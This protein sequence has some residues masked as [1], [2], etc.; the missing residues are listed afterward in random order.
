[1]SVVNEF[2]ESKYYIILGYIR[3]L[4]N[5]KWIWRVSTQNFSRNPRCVCYAPVSFQWQCSVNSLSFTTLL[6][7]QDECKLGMDD[8][9]VNAE[10]TDTFGTYTCKCKDGWTGDGFNCTSE[11]MIRLETKMG[12]SSFVAHFCRFN[13]KI[14]TSL[15]PWWHWEYFCNLGY[16]YALFYYYYLWN[17]LSLQ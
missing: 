10:C 11:S 5:E 2:F 6:A 17:I 12:K 1:M 4:I 9:D 13:H 3:K 7:T 8:C 14:K 16:R 15:R